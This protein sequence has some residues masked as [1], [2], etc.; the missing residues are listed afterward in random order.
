MFNDKAAASK[1]ICT[2]R[3]EVFHKIKTNSGQHNPDGVRIY[4]I[5]HPVLYTEEPMHKLSVAQLFGDG[6]TIYPS[7]L[8]QIVV[9][10]VG[11]PYPFVDKPAFQ[12]LPLEQKNKVY[13]E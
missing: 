3:A 12:A 9:E 11:T 1:S 4:G 8:A 6:G 10:A 7:L 13:W 2:C 5:F